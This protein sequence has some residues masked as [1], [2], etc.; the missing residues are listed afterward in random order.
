M[1]LVLTISI[2]FSVT[3]LFAQLPNRAKKLEGRWIFDNSTSYEEWMLNG[4]VL[5]GSSYRVTKLSDTTLTET[6]MIK[7]AAGRM[8]HSIIS[9]KV[10]NDTVVNNEHTFIGRKRRLIFENITD[11][12]PYSIAYHFGFLNRNKLKIKIKYGMNEKPVKFI[13]HRLK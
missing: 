7:R 12:A 10:S 13:L 6:L 11:I 8:V 3:T 1:R 2:L 4:E 5:E 9:H